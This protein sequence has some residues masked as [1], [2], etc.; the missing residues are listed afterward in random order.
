[1]NIYIYK[2]ISIASGKIVLF[3]APYVSYGSNSQYR[4]DGPLQAAKY[5]AVAALVRSIGPFSLYTPHTGSSET[6][7]IPG[8]AI[9]LEDADQIVS[10]IASGQTVQ[11]YLYMEAHF[12]PD[13]ISRNII[14]EVR[15]T[16]YPNEVVV[17]GGHIDSWDVGT[18]VLDDAGGAFAAWD[19][20]RLMGKYNLRP[21]RTV[22]V[23]MWT[24]Y[25]IVFGESSF[26]KKN[27][28]L[29]KTE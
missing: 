23:V 16:T 3:N 2:Y 14:A 18:G 10:W 6:T 11:F 26:K 22:R 20:L 29:F 19:A 4:F 21:K 5:G 7:T 1:M 12:E 8:A 9:T 13:K 17:M 25:I 15:G 27:R 24:V 28:L